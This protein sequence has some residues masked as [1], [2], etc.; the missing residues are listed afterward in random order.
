MT[1]EG[2]RNYNTQPTEGVP[3][4]AAATVVAPARK[5][6][7]RAV[8]SASK[9]KLGTTRKRK[10]ASEHATNDKKRQ[11]NNG[12]GPVN[13]SI[14]PTTQDEFKAEPKKEHQGLEKQEG[15]IPS[16]Y[17][18]PETARNYPVAW[19]TRLEI[20]DSKY[21]DCPDNELLPFERKEKCRQLKLKE[22][23]GA[24]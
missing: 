19:R 24:R 23:N 4:V 3:T 7:A 1:R 12:E 8:A 22:K 6:T 10:D 17:R 14:Q 15:F 5:Y 20:C 9:E 13:K 18:D 11:K 21:E 2:L 16:G